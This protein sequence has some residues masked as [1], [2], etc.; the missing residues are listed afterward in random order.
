MLLPGPQLHQ[1]LLV[2]ALVSV[3]SASAV[4]CKQRVWMD[5]REETACPPQPLGSP[6]RAENS[7]QYPGHPCGACAVAQGAPR[8]H[9]HRFCRDAIVGLS[10]DLR[11]AQAPV[12]E[13]AAGI[14]SAWAKVWPVTC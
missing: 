6:A 2:C 3:H 1:H 5:R 7:R 8:E 9:G 11:P 13:Q 10:I 12:Q 14:L 4:L